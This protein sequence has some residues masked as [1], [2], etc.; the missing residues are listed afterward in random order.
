M[1]VPLVLIQLK[2]AFHHSNHPANLGNPNL[3]KPPYVYIYIWMGDYGNYFNMFD[4]VKQL[5]STARRATAP[6]SSTDQAYNPQCV[7]VEASSITDFFLTPHLFSG[8]NL[9]SA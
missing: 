6:P 8:S 2:L 7:L 3:W 1:G 4:A 9:K 5:F